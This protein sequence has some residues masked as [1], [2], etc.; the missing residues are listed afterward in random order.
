MSY[1]CFFVLVKKLTDCFHTENIDSDNRNC[2]MALEST[3]TLRF[4][5]ET[6]VANNVPSSIN[7]ERCALN[8]D[9]INVSIYSFKNHKT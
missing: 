9:F 2:A 3:P 1:T 6:E 8:V 4:F 5:L 7:L